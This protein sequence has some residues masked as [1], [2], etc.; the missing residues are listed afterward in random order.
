V[1]G[2][3]NRGFTVGPFTVISGRFTLKTLK[4]VALDTSKI[5]TI[6]MF[7]LM[8]AQ[9]FALSFR[10]LHGEDVISKMFEALPGG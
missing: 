9:V 7:I 2:V 3:V 6:M 4:A 10:G 5:T 8:A 1:K